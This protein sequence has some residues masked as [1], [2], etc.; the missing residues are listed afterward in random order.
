[1]TIDQVLSKK[2]L[3]DLN[4]LFSSFDYLETDI[5]FLATIGVD[6]E[7]LGEAI[8]QR[9][10]QLVPNHYLEL[11]IDDFLNN[12]LPFFRQKYPTLQRLILLPLYKVDSTN[13][14]NIAQQLLAY[15]D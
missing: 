1:M 4:E 5:P 3:L 14:D 12:P 2:D 11:A 6:S 8:I 13:L 10:Q 7:R 15:R 9:C